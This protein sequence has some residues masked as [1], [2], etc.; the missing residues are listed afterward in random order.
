MDGDGDLGQTTG[1][2]PSQLHMLSIVPGSSYL[3][4]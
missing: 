2:S 4:L 3:L 1:T